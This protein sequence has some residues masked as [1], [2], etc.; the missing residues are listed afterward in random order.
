MAN[1]TITFTN[2]LP[3]GIQIGDIAW[4]SNTTSGTE[5]EMGP[6]TAITSN[7]I[8]ISINATAGAQPPSV[9]D[10]VFYVKNP[11]TTVSSLK[12]YYAEAQFRNNSPAYG[13][14]FSVGSE[15]FVSSK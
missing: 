13:E 9:S 12:G 3:D 7:P 4:Y 8:T 2:P 10:F 14:L 15:V 5:V 1:I 11:M 6:I